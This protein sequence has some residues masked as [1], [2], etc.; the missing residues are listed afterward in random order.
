MAVGVHLSAGRDS[1]FYLV[2]LR[3]QRIQS[4]TRMC[5]PK[6]NG[7]GSQMSLNKGIKA[8]EFRTVTVEKLGVKPLFIDCYCV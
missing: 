5:C 2:Q 3:P 1:N 8:T 7:K 4:K 6:Q